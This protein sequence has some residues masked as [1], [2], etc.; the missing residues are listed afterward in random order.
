MFSR[1]HCWGVAQASLT[2]EPI[3]S[4]NNDTI[5]PYPLKRIPSKAD[6]KILQFVI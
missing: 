3:C 4:L 2:P 6:G 1:S 5:L